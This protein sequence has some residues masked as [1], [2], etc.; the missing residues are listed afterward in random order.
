MLLVLKVGDCLLP[1]IPV[2]GNFDKTVAV[3]EMIPLRCFV[4]C[5]SMLK[6]VAGVVLLFTSASL[7][8][9]YW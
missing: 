2:F 6:R 3:T 9:G 1:L 5:F 7:A 4:R 8:S